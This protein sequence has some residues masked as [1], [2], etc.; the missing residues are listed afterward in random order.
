MEGG[1]REDG[2]RRRGVNRY[3]GVP[4]WLDVKCGVFNKYNKITETV[5]LGFTTSNTSTTTS[6]SSTTTVTAANNNDS[7]NDIIYTL[8]STYGGQQVGAGVAHWDHPQHGGLPRLGSCIHSRLADGGVR[9]RWVRLEA[10]GGSGRRRWRSGGGRTRRRVGRGGHVVGRGRRRGGGVG[11]GEGGGGGGDSGGGGGGRGRGS[12][13]GGLG[14]GDGW[15][16]WGRGR[17]DVV[18]GDG[19]GLAARRGGRRNVSVL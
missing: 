10:C 4:Q 18:L 8:T 19:G 7:F 12:V 1:W 16:R 9:R 17:R 11:T 6:S 13:E 3:S 2:R 14:R 15:G 5:F